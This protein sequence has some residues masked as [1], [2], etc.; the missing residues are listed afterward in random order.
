MAKFAAQA[1]CCSAQV[2]LSFFEHLLN[3]VWGCLH[4]FELKRICVVMNCCSKQPSNRFFSR[5]LCY[6]SDILTYCTVSHFCIWCISQYAFPYL[7][8]FLLFGHII[9]T[10]FKMLH[11]TIKR[12][13]IYSSLQSIGSKTI[14]Q[15]RVVSVH[16]HQVLAQH[17]P[18]LAINILKKPFFV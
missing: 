12:L 4:H 15:N 5:F 6:F 8:C 9:N 10:V 11:N 2:F 17:F 18:P 7:V 14:K 1:S 3:E 13:I 16:L